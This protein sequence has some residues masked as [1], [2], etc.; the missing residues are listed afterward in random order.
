VR[1]DTFN[2]TAASSTSR[3]S[4]FLTWGA[5]L[6]NAVYCGARFFRAAGLRSAIP[7]EPHDGVQHG[8]QCVLSGCNPVPCLCHLM[9]LGAFYLPENARFCKEMDYSAFS[10]ALTNFVST[11]M[12]MRSINAVTGRTAARRPRSQDYQYCSA[13]MAS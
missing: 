5:G 3:I 13:S 12:A 7:K 4:P 1:R 6:I 11:V 2:S 8:V 10:S 9:P